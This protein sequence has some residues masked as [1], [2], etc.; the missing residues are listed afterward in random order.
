MTVGPSL[1]ELK[2][3]LQQVRQS[4]IGFL[5]TVYRSSTPKYA[6]QSDLLTGE[7]S[8]RFGGRWNPVGISA[9]YASL[10]PE[11]AMAE[12]LA[13]NRYYGIPVEDAMPRTFVAIEVSLKEVIDL[14]IGTVRQRLKVSLD[15]MV[16]VDWRTVVQS[17]AEPLPQ[18]IGRAASDI[19]LEGLIV[20]SAADSSGHNLLVFPPN[21][22][23]NSK[24]RV[25][26]TERL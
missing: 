3:R 22:E 8:R 14:R 23:G 26:N 17:G 1:D 2:K 7:G 25:L 12:T 5:S 18:R 6:N 24:I 4:A 21:L 11:T 13:H 19:G 10:S 16:N 15:R 9:V 20:P